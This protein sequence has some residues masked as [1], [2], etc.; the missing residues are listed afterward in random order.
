MTLFQPASGT[1]V[2]ALQNTVV[3]IDQPAVAPAGGWETLTLNGVSEGA[4]A[5]AAIPSPLPS[6]E[7]FLTASITTALVPGTTYR[8]AVTYADGCTG[9]TDSLTLGSFTAQ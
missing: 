4:L 3:F 7:A 2:S 1:T 5:P 9:A 6:G 8:V